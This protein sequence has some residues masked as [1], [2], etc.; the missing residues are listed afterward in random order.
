MTCGNS[1]IAS[2]GSMLDVLKT[3]VDLTKKDAHVRFWY[4]GHGRAGWPLQ[5]GVYRDS[6]SEAGISKGDLLRKEQNMSQD[7]RI[8]S[9][10]IRERG[11]TRVELYF[12][13]QHYGM[14]TRLLDWTT[15]PLAAL[16][17][18]VNDESQD[19]CDAEFFFLD[20]NEFEITQNTSDAGRAPDYKERS[21]RFWGYADSTHPI[22]VRCVENIFYFKGLDSF[23]DFVFPVRPDHNEKRVSLQKSCFTFHVPDCPEV[24]LSNNKTL[25]KFV[26][27]KDSKQGI[28]NDLQV[29]GLDNYAIFGDLEALSR[30]LQSYYRPR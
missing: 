13:L 25:K 10:G 17:F 5:P 23:P 16:F 12:V 28:R 22:M 14:P 19:N 21:P 26:I 15:S 9:A 3:E 27:P 6:F 30:S 11:Q 1:Y 4:R 20:A 29:L 24:N 18:A 8:S 2:V 7:F